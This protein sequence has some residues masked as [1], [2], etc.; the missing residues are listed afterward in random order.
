MTSVPTSPDALGQD[1]PHY[2]RQTNSVYFADYFNVLLF[3]YS[4]A[5]NKTYSCTVEGVLNPSFIFPVRDSYDQFL[6]GSNNSAVI[7]NWDGESDTGYI[8]RTVFSVTPNTIINNA[9]VTE[10]GDMYLGNYGPTFCNTGPHLSFY[11]YTVDGGLVEIANHYRSTVGVLIVEDTLYHLDACS[12]I[13]SAYKRDPV[14]GEFG[15][16]EI[17]TEKWNN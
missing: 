6:V 5:E 11:K 17:F 2:D 16:I 9:Y 1:N 4:L 10:S 12:Q 8:E 7:V 13:L 15:K 14:T 3:R